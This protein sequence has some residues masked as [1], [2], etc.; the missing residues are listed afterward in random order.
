MKTIINGIIITW[1]KLAGYS[2]EEI[3]A[4]IT[5][6]VPGGTEFYSH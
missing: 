3:Y 6:D 5:G 1:M 2:T 4:K